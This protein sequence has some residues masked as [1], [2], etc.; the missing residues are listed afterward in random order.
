MIN[1]ETVNAINGLLKTKIPL[2]RTLVQR[3]KH[4]NL[5][6]SDNSEGDDKDDNKDDSDYD[7]E[8]EKQESYKRLNDGGEGVPF[9][10]IDLQSSVFKSIEAAKSLPIAKHKANIM[11]K[12]DRNRVL[13]ISGDTGC[14]K[15]T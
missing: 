2:K 10:N 4:K 9:I 14:G 1:I 12:L 7:D 15:T 11:Q 13:I 3:Q 5:N 6:N 8:I